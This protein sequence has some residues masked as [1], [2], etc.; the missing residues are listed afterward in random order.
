ML[1]MAGKDLEESESSLVMQIDAGKII[2]N[3]AMCSCQIRQWR[4]EVAWWRKR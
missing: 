2:W 3:V 4:V 1:E